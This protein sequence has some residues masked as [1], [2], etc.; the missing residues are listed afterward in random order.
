MDLLDIRNYIGFSLDYKSILSLR[1]VCKKWS[2]FYGDENYWLSKCCHDF[3]ISSARYREI[4]IDLKMDQEVYVYLCGKYQYPVYG[5][6]KYGKIYN[7]AKNAILQT[8]PDVP[9]VEHFAKLCLDPKILSIVSRF[10]YPRL[11]NELSLIY[12]DPLRQIAIGA[13]RSGNME[14]LSTIP[15]DYTML[16]DDGVSLISKALKS[17]N[18]SMVEKIMSWDKTKY[19]LY[20]ACKTEKLEIVDWVLKMG[21]TDYDAFCQACRRGN[22]AIVDRLLPYCDG[23]LSFGAEFAAENGHFRIMEKLLEKDKATIGGAFPGAAHG[24]YL[25]QVEKLYHRYPDISQKIIN[26][27][28]ELAPVK[29]NLQLIKLLIS[30]GANSYDIALLHAAENGNL[31]ILKFLR[32]YIGEMTDRDFAAYLDQVRHDFYYCGYYIDGQLDISNYHDI[33]KFREILR[34]IPEHKYENLLEVVVYNGNLDIARELMKILDPSPELLNRI[35]C[36]AFDG[37]HFHIV[38]YLVSQGLIIPENNIVYG[39]DRYKIAYLKKLSKV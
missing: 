27:A 8:N 23:L 7:L 20:F 36:R 30:Y 2:Q 25:S 9:L 26:R 29:G 15:A 6:E 31:E 39:L 14:L 22:E 34:Y 38:I 4:K 33:D 18:L 10:N 28:F 21:A 35:I 16:K 19:L 11:I 17:G 13:C 37:N 12:P 3:N 1:R 5:A 24:G 32:S